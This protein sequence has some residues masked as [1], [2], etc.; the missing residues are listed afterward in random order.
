MP[1]QVI[2]EYGGFSQS[3][4]RCH[5]VFDPQRSRA[6]VGEPLDN[7]GTSVTN[8]IEEI[9]FSLKTSLNVEV[10]RGGQLYQYAPWD[11]AVRRERTL[12]VEFRGDAWSMPVWTDADE[13]EFLAAALAEVHAIHPYALSAMRHLPLVKSVVRVRVDA[14]GVTAA[15][16]RLESI[17]YVAHI[18][19]RRF[20]YVDVRA[21]SDEAAVAV[22]CEA[23]GGQVGPDG[24]HAT[25]PNAP[26][27]QPGTLPL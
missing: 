7:P 3:R 25:T 13:S 6:L 19:Q 15:H 23:L 16:D 11:A 18:S 21:T 27:D 1:D 4:G 8:A 9:A 14:A 5:V 24:V 12:L 22:V 17:G 10:T 26:L 20:Y 2:L